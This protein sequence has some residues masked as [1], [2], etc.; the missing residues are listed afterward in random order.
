MTSPRYYP[1]MWQLKMVLRVHPIILKMTSITKMVIQN[2]KERINQQKNCVKM[3]K[4]Y[5]IAITLCS[6]LAVSCEN[7]EPNDGLET[8]IDE[9]AILIYA[10][11]AD[12][13]R[14]YVSEVGAS[15]GD[16]STI[17]WDEGDQVGVY[18]SGPAVETNRCF[19]SLAGAGVASATFKGS[20]E[21]KAT[22]GNFT[23]YAYSPY[24]LRQVPTTP[25]LQVI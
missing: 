14:A 18:V 11:G 7:I 21:N 19:T 1:S 23:Y 3:K 25:L 17:V 6:L 12:A 16:P 13:T 22:T 8:Q 20:F 10:A 2:G 9:N 24:T 5:Y 4:L 15:T